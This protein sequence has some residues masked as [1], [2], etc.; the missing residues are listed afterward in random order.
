ME[1]K[2]SAESLRIYFSGPAPRRFL[3]HPDVT[4]SERRT[5]EAAIA[6]AG[7]AAPDLGLMRRADRLIRLYR[8]THSPSEI[9]RQRA[10]RPDFAESEMARYSSL[11]NRPDTDPVGD[12]RTFRGSLYDMF[13]RRTIYTP[14]ASIALFFLFWFLYDHMPGVREEAE[15]SDHLFFNIADYPVAR[16]KCKAEGKRLPRTPE[17]LSRQV[18]M[19][20]EGK[21]RLGYWLDGGRVYLPLEDRIVPAD[22]RMRWYLCVEKE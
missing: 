16:Y 11:R 9:D 6:T 1:S 12:P 22:E 15:R 21:A 5:I 20:N 19:W 18:E 8:E 2:K 10:Q 17:E 7:S 14:I 13:K 3:Q 4:T